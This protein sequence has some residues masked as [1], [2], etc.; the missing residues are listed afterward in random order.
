MEDEEEAPSVPASPGAS[1]GMI[2]AVYAP[3]PGPAAPEAAQQAEQEV[4]WRGRACACRAVPPM[5]RACGCC[6]CWAAA[7]CAAATWQL[8]D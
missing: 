3:A 2:P 8:P 4:R 5:S 1:E 7:W 6:R